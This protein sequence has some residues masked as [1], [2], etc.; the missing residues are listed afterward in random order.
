MASKEELKLIQEGYRNTF[1]REASPTIKHFIKHLYAMHD[2]LVAK[3]GMSD[4]PD[5]AFGLLKEARGI[6]KVLNH[7]KT[8]TGTEISR[9]QA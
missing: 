4:E 6:I 9:E 3:A 2:D 7:I 1:V 8:Q 5:V